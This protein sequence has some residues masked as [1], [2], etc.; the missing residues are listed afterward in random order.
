MRENNVVPSQ[1]GDQQ[2]ESPRG[3]WFLQSSCLS[4]QDMYIS[5]QLGMNPYSGQLL[6]GGVAEEACSYK[7]G[8]DS[9]CC[10]V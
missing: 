4:G 7:H 5:G 1:K 3:Y 10:R 6:P 8:R 2:L 9:E